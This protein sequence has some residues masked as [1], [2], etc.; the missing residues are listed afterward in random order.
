MHGVRHTSLRVG[1]FDARK[2]EQLGQHAVAVLRV[3]AEPLVELSPH[4]SRHIGDYAVE[5]LTSLFVAIE[6]VMD[7]RAQVASSL[8]STVGVC[9]ADVYGRLG[10][11]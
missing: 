2:W 5:R 11:L 7:V 9:V 4:S 10:T 3:L 6:V 8:R 1:L